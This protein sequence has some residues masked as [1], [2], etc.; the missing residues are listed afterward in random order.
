MTHDFCDVFGSLRS[1][2]FVGVERRTIFLA[3]RSAELPSSAHG[4]QMKGCSHLKLLALITRAAR[5]VL[6]QACSAEISNVQ[7]DPAI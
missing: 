4:L 5:I 3:Q 6:I 2:S 7:Q 1:A